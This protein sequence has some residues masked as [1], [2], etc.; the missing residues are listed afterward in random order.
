MIHPTIELFVPKKTGVFAVADRLWDVLVQLDRCLVEVPTCTPGEQTRTRPP[1]AA[2]STETVPRTTMVSY[3]HPS[4]R[5]EA[6][7]AIFGQVTGVVTVRSSSH[8]RRV[9]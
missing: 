9:L 3:A 5:V 2:H 1:D 4:C 8:S 7:R 6:L